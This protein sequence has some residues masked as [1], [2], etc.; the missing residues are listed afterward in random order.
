MAD[1]RQALVG[2]DAS[3]LG[4]RHLADCEPEAWAAMSPRERSFYEMGRADYAIT[5]AAFV[6]ES[7]SSAGVVGQKDPS[8]G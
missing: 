7:I 5:V 8:D 1:D 3:S 6:A 2:Q 4:P